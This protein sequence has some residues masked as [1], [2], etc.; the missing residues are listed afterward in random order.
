[1]VYE[2]GPIPGVATGDI[3]WQWLANSR[4]FIVVDAVIANRDFHKNSRATAKYTI[5]DGLAAQQ[6]C[7]LPDTCQSM[8]A[9]V[10]LGRLKADAPILNQDAQA[11]AFLDQFH[12]DLFTPAV[13][14]CIC[15]KFSITP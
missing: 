2:D 9:T 15:R 10:R 1:M 7:S 13:A 11:L 12:A 14:A 6:L 4:R 3:K 8:P 5:D